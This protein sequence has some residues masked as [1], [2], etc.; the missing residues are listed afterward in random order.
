[1][2]ARI[3]P[4]SARWE[5]REVDQRTLDM[6]AF[7]ARVKNDRSWFATIDAELLD[8]VTNPLYGGVVELTYLS[9][10][11]Q[12]DPVIVTHFG[13]PEWL[14]VERAGGPPWTGPVG[15]LVVRALDFNGKPVSGLTCSIGGESALLTDDAGICRY[16]GVAAVEQR[17]ELWAGIEESTHV[18]GSDAVVV[19]PDDLTT[20]TIVVDLP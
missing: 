20:V 10:S 14:R 6:I 16:S 9:R 2:L 11:R 15:D 17:I 3:L 7:V 5:A 1:V 12:L 13:S 19:K 18:V 4:P 8:V